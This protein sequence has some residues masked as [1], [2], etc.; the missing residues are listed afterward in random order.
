[1][2]ST[3]DDFV[4]NNPIAVID[5][6]LWDDKIP[7][8]VMQFRNGP[9][10]Y[11]PLIEW[12]DR[13]AQTGAQTSEY[14]ELLEGDTD[15]DD[16]AMNAQYIEE[17]LAVDSRKRQITVLRYGDKTQLLETSNI[18]QMF[19][20]SGN[21]DWRPLLRGL[22]GKNV[23]HK[24]ELVSRNAYLRGPKDYWT[25]GGNAVDFSGLDSTAKFG[26]DIANAWN[27]RL[28]NIGS[29]VI[30]GE[31]ASAKLAIIPPGAIY[32]FQASLATASQNEAALYTQARLYAGTALPYEL[33]TYKNVRF[34]EVPNDKYGQ[35]M[36]V[37]YNAGAITAQATVMAAIAVG[38]GSPNPETT[39]VDETW[40][41][42]QKD[43]THY[44]QL[45]TGQAADFE[46]NDM[47]TIHSVRTNAY[48]VTNGVDPLSG[49]TIVRRVVSVDTVNDRLSFDRPIMRKYSVDLGSG[50]YAFVTKGQHVGFVLV[51]GSLGGIK[52]NVNR[53]LKFYEPKAI[54]DFESVNHSVEPTINF[55]NCW[56]LHITNNR[57]SVAT[58]GKRDM[59]KKV[60]V[61]TISSRASLPLAI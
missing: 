59:L 30:P 39:K 53:P 18:F 26:L 37:L 14:T 17:P 38:A 36:A 57:Y 60:V 1:M 48:G 11:T 8:V 28:G 55:E 42:G 41:V 47:V 34:M 40:F 51:L 13:S 32:D 33:G 56:K 20:I 46:K 5:Q 23:Q 24:M 31:S 12:T 2:A 3:Y 45:D 58:N 6:N 16:I 44:I 29:P 15:F 43:V 7:E 50:V 22:L 25:Y 61:G 52:G 19:K 4:A 21:R 54:D 49:K 9:T 35:N 27:L 10:I